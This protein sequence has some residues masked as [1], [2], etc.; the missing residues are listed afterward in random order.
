MKNRVDLA[1][2]RVNYVYD[3]Y[4]MMNYAFFDWCYKFFKAFLKILMFRRQ[5]EIGNR[6]MVCLA[7]ATHHWMFD[8]VVKPKAKHINSYQ[9]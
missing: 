8:N 7:V 1:I 5:T 2:Q 4:A 9:W 3:V 6:N